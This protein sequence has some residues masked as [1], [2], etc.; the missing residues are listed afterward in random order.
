M[1]QFLS[2]FTLIFYCINFGLCQQNEL[3]RSK[4]DSLNEQAFKL[5]ASNP[6]KALAILMQTEVAANEQQYKKGLSENY[7]YQAG[8][9]YQ[10]GFEKRALAL[11]YKSIEISKANADTFNIAR[12]QQQIAVSLIKNGNYA[13][14]EK[15]LWDVV[16]AYQKR[17]LTNDVVNTYNTLGG[18]YLSKQAFAEAYNILIE[19][20]ALSKKNKYTY[21]EKKALYLIGKAHLTQ[22]KYVSADS[23]TTAALKINQQVSD[24]YGVAQCYLQLAAIKKN[25]LDNNQAVAFANESFNAA[26]NIKA[27]QLMLDALTFEISC[28]KDLKDDKKIITTQDKVIALEQ[29]IFEKER[30]YMGEFTNMLKEQELTIKKSND[31]ALEAELVSKGQRLWLIIA[32]MLLMAVIFMAI[33][34]YANYRKAFKASNDLF[35]NNEIIVKNASELANLN[36]EI[37]K[38]NEKLA[39]ENKMKD[40]LLSI[41]SHDL[42]HPLVNT[43][44]ILDLINL[45][46]ISPKEQQD[47][48]DQLE[49][50]YVNSLTLLDN[51]LFWIRSQMMGMSMELM[52]INMRTLLAQLIDEQRVPLNKKAII[53]ENH[54][55]GN[56]VWLGEREMLKI[57]FRNLISNAIKFTP[58]EGKIV[59]AANEENAKI[60]AI[61]IKDSG[62][63]MSKEILEKVNARNYYSGKGTSNEKGSGFGLILVRD[64]VDKHSGTFTI[65]SEVGKGSIFTVIFP[66]DKVIG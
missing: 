63:G 7:L 58:Q 48:L 57:I 22:H 53:I 8:I 37:S 4:I 54:V 23:A 19:A 31:K 56:T 50:Q 20:D 39:A 27:L 1:K 29:T 10:N 61:T 64:L 36:S 42:R 62:I 51:L 59:I 35:I 34:A 46:L 2:L 66:E 6:S 11:F 13:D 16:K 24:A 9:F 17:Q 25:Q 52:K 65:S 32:S 14:A 41:I 43:K 21:G 49:N 33:Q 3:E 12:A 5:K 40:K 28:F 55:V 18:L 60:N 45:N 26:N 44:S 38:Q 15:M 30:S 47:L